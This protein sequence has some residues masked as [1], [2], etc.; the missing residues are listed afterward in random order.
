M[1]TGIIERMGRVQRLIRQGDGARLTIR[2]DGKW[3]DLR[4][5]E[6]IAV[7]G[8]C[9]TIVEKTRETFTMDLSPETLKRSALG[10]LRPGEI[11]N[12]ERSLRPSDR[13][14]GHFVTGH[15]DGIGR[16][17]ALVPEGNSIRAEYSVPPALAPYLVE[18]GSVAVDGISLTVASCK[19]E[20]FTVSL[21]PYTLEKT[22]LKERKVGD[23][24]NI[25]VDILGKYVEAFLARQKGG[26]TLEALEKAGFS[27]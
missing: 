4:T 26:V 1:F 27:S 15:I 6:S 5:G 16:I 3:D 23:K 20:R 25:E 22:N 21:I 7:N 10:G 17:E 18:K 2:L 13:I 12:L 24:V 8:L 9:L 11:V 14:G 19:R